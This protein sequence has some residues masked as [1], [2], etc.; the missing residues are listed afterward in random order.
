MTPYYEQDGITIYHGDCREVLPN[1]GLVDHVL[2]DPPYGIGYEK[3][4]SHND[5]PEPYG[6]FIWS[7]IES[8]EHITAPS[9]SVTVFQSVDT[10]RRWADWFPR[11]WQIIA[12][13]KSFTQMGRE[14]L[15]RG[16]DF[17]LWWPLADHPT[18]PQKWQPIPSRNWYV[19]RQVANTANRPDHPCPR[20]IDTMK[21]LVSVMCAPDSLVLD[22]F[23]GSGTTL[24]AAKELGRRAI[25]IEIEERYCEIAA[26]RLAQ[27]VLPLEMPA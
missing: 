11:D 3:Y 27:R 14:F 23:S 12:L 26:K 20:G 16:C 25:G 5:D 22:C 9:G 7:V 6:G 15:A 10:A 19:S 1:I 8:A 2:T 18:N 4:L 17:A 13:P 21:Y 24:L